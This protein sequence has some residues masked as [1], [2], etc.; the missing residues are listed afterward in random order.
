MYE[1]YFE[2]QIHFFKTNINQITL[3]CEDDDGY[4]FLFSKDD[5]LRC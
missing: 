2:A 1:L 4:K 5:I 3:K